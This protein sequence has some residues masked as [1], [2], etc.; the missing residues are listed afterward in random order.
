[1]ARAKVTDL[2]GSATGGTELMGEDENPEP[3]DWHHD[4]RLGR[5]VPEY[6]CFPA[7]PV[8]R[9]DVPMPAPLGP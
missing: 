5:K 4:H 1:M 2:F 6:R 7:E 9:E 3:P 8:I